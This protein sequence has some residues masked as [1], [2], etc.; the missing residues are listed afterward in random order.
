MDKYS[1]GP[2]EAGAKALSRT[3]S[4]TD[5]DDDE[6]EEEE[7]EEQDDEVTPPVVDIVVNPPDIIVEGVQV[8]VKLLMD[9][10]CIY[11]AQSSSNGLLNSLL[12]LKLFYILF[13]L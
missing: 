12:F 7:E 5:Y 1:V 13:A 3:R 10:Y 2:A 6:E 11:I 4:T 9:T 8:R